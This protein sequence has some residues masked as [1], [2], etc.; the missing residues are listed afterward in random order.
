[1]RI[2]LLTSFATGL[3][4]ATSISAIGYFSD[5]NDANASSESFVKQETVKVQPTNKEMKKELESTGY[6]VLTKEEYDKLGDGKAEKPKSQNEEDKTATK[7]ESKKS[8][9][10]EDSTDTSKEKEKPETKVVVNVTQGMTS[11]D[12]GRILKD[13]EL[14][15]DAFKFSRHIEIKG[16]QKELR[17]GKYEVNSSMSYDQIIST[18]FVKK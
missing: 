6:V 3:L 17:P 9:S 1:M 10:K 14:I 18:I 11:I 15:P 16:L 13:A 5:K 2:N 12:V 8:T 7:E 4:I